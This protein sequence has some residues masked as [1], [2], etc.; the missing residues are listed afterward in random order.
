[1]RG[2]SGW[3]TP[4]SFD[5]INSVWKDLS[6]FQKNSTIASGISVKVNQAGSYGAGKSFKYV[7]GTTQSKI[8]FGA[9]T[10][11]VKSICAMA[12]YIEG[13][14]NGMERI[15]QSASTNMVFGHHGGYNG[16][17]MSGNW[18]TNYPL[19][20]VSPNYNWIY[21]CTSSNTATT[22]TRTYFNGVDSTG[23]NSNRIYQSDVFAINP[24]NAYQQSSNFGFTELLLWNR[25]LNLD[26]MF[27]ASNYLSSKYGI[28]SKYMAAVP[29]VFSFSTPH[30]YG[31][32]VQLTSQYMYLRGATKYIVSFSA[33][34]F[35]QER[36][37]YLRIWRGPTVG[38]S[39]NA[40]YSFSGPSN[41]WI[42]VTIATSASTGIIMQFTSDGSNEY[43]GID[44]TVT[45]VISQQLS[46]TKIDQ[47]YPMPSQVFPNGAI[48]SSPDLQ[49]LIVA[50]PYKARGGVDR[51][52]MVRVD[53]NIRNNIAF[54]C[55]VQV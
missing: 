22:S 39:S 40:V 21:V 35:T 3:Y 43:Y 36:Y 44:A 5:S 11:S 31:S 23:S 6:V 24:T 27:K 33:Q 17:Y 41:N 26:E 55:A 1:M 10:T 54:A 30:K 14:L 29:N 53:V 7:T 49:S 38:T 18:I 12:R 13:D 34:S 45:P 25:T 20:V 48:D 32:N 9:S 15:L 16:V 2:L 4:E 51:L 19:S 46:P 42:S 8:H 50:A 28:G 47:N 37:D 52:A